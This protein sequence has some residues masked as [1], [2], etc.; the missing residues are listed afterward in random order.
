[1]VESPHN[2]ILLQCGSVPWENGSFSR[3]DINSDLVTGYD[4][5]VEVQTPA[6][7]DFLGLGVNW[8]LLGGKAAGQPLPS[9]ISRKSQAI[10]SLIP[11]QNGRFKSIFHNNCRLLILRICVK[12]FL[13][14]R[15]VYFTPQPDFDFLSR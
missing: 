1:M 8:A 6:N 3:Y 15:L 2:E 7:K 5:F 13:F 4:D 14:L 12:H 10:L 11:D 9:T